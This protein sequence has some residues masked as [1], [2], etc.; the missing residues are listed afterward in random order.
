[1]DAPVAVW[2]LTPRPEMPPIQVALH[3]DCGTSAG[4]PE[5]LSSSSGADLC[6]SRDTP[7]VNRPNLIGVG[8]NLLGM[9]AVGSN[10]PTR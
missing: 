8:D 3:I 9:T 4:S 5:L 10:H 7:L 2:I 1:M 6:D